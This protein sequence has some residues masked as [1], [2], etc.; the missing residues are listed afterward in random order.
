MLTEYIG[1]RRRGRQNAARVWMDK[2]ESYIRDLGEPSNVRCLLEAAVMLSLPNYSGPV[3]GQP[4]MHSRLTAPSTSPMCGATRIARPPREHPALTSLA[5]Q[6]RIRLGAAGESMWSENS[7]TP[8]PHDA[9]P[10]IRDELRTR[11][12]TMEIIY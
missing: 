6:G 8:L 4:T 11:S 2:T 5:Q 7:T 9:A 12:A 3:T 10:V 1:S